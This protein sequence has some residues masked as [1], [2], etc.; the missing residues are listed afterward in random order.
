MTPFHAPPLRILAPPPVHHLLPH[1]CGPHH[2]RSAS[3]DPTP[4]TLQLLP[5]EPQPHPDDTLHTRED[6]LDVHRGPRGLLVRTPFGCLR[7]DGATLQ[8]GP[9]LTRHDTPLPLRSPVLRMGLALA[10]SLRGLHALHAALVL[11][12]TLGT[13]LLPGGSGA[14]KTT[15]T[16]ALLHDGARLLTD[17]LCFLL[18]RND[19]PTRLVG[20]PAPLH[21]DPPTAD[22]LHA[23]G[24]PVP[25][26]P[27]RQAWNPE[28]TFPLHREPCP[29]PTRVLLPSVN[30]DSPTRSLPLPRPLGL[31]ETLYAAPM[32]PLLHPEERARAQQDIAT[33]LRKST[34]QRI[35]LGHDLRDNPS[36]LPHAIARLD[37]DPPA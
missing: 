26:Q 19:D 36:S 21:L 8:L 6:H 1:V 11:H 14:G 15:S 10:A 32:L 20:W 7:L 22:L 35:A 2:P 24:H 12:P 9:S 13:I 23:W 31:A 37:R 27:R 30:L 25:Q 33:L 5:H 29:P 28:P 34:F 17:E 4:L 16:L 3:L 18:P